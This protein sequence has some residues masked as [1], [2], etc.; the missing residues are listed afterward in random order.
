MTKN[1]IS[2]EIDKQEHK[3]YYSKNVEDNLVNDIQSLHSDRKVLFIYD[4]NISKK[5]ILNIKTK[6]KLTGNLIFFKKVYGQKKNKNLKT[7]LSLFDELV[8]NKFTKNSV[9]I[10]CGG[11]VIGDLSGL[12][13]SLYLRGTIYFHIPSTMTAIVDSCIG[14][15]TGIN[16][17]GIINSFGNY[18]HPKRVYI[19]QKIIEELPER[20]YFSGFAEIIKCGLIGNRNI[21]RILQKDKFLFKRKKINTISKVILETLKT[22]I[23]FFKDDVREQNQRLILNFGHTFAHAIEMATDKHFKNDYLRHG[24]AVGLGMLCE[25]MMSQNT[26]RKNN[27]NNVYYMTK[28]LLKKYNLPTK[29]KIPNKLNRKIHSGIYEGVFL[30]KKIKNK[31]PRFI[32]LKK[33]C[34]PKIEEIKDFGALND[35][36]YKITQN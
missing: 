7:L 17:K 16:Y 21:I 36:I 20:E 15:K 5:F 2:Y 19:S 26:N 24:E 14:G 35:S 10:S 3:V 6:L 25:I 32:S 31:Y 33:I 29:L 27:S 23:K 4:R 22:K 9:I 18:Y 30:D 28:Q 8:K 34:S 1:Q 11:G 13:S 12:L